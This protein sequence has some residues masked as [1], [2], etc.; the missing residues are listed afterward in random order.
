MPSSFAWVDFAE[1]DRQRMM[2]ILHLFRDKE[3]REELGVGT[4][5]DAFSDI[6]FP[7]TSTLHTRVKYML[8]IPWIFIKLEG[9]KTS[10]EKI[11]EYSRWYEIR[12]VKVL[13]EERETDGV[14]GK[15]AKDSLKILP[16]IMYWSGLGKWGIRIFDGTLYQYFRALDN[17]YTQK[18]KVV[19]SDDNELI[20]KMANNWDPHLPSYPK[21]FPDGAT[22]QLKRK[23]ATYLQHRIL[24][25]CSSSLL[26]YLMA[27]TKRTNVDFVWFHQEYGSFN[28]EHK[29][30]VTHA[31][32]FS[33]SIYGASL[34]YNLMLSQ[35]A[36]MTDRIDE[37]S[38][39]ISQW[40]SLMKDR[41]RE[42]QKWD[43]KEFWE[44]VFLENPRINRLTKR[45]IENWIYLIRSIRD[46]SKLG[47]ND[48]ARQLIYKREVRIKGNRSRLKNPRMLAQWGGA[49][50][51]FPIGFRWK[52]ARKIIEDIHKGLRRD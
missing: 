15:V 5:R 11:A 34:L 25:S 52:I 49:S 8:F 48:S 47:G 16:S 26:G 35:E 18:E 50:G 9:S 44:T 33:D 24:T 19:K 51:A 38:D 17:F 45:F 7:G 29:R 12:L 37:Y 20:A 3:I 42:F 36:N 13:L 43:L 4:V 21:N 2:E 10:S 31:R 22:L 28:E 32:N 27:K 23:E 30:I 41:K 1:D 39:K 46:L 6:L 40:S 14:I